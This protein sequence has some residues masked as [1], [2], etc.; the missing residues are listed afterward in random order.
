[1]GR[2]SD[3]TRSELAALFVSE[4]W[5]HLA[6]VGLAR[7]SARE[8][9][10]CAGYTIG[11]I[12]NVFGNTEGLLLAINARTLALWAD[13]VRTRLAAP[14]AEPI[15]TLVR[16]Y[17]DFATANPLCWM[18]IFQQHLA[19]DRP[20]PAWYRAAV[21]ELMSIVAGGI[22]RALPEA[23]AER[24]QSLTR[25]LVATV[26]GHCMF[27]LVHTFD[28]LGET[29]PVGAALTRVREALDAARRADPRAGDL[30]QR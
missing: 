3:H 4:G 15:E 2:R 23:D 1:M 29:D 12:H 20:A 28:L 13:H 9:A 11:S 19:D 16:A 6:A 24:I 5:Q 25:S 22:A 21:A 30:P 26:H 18:A 8:V 17:F 14:G 10:K 27:S 7:F